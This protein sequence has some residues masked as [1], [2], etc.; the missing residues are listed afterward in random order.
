MQ[1]FLPPGG[2]WEG[3]AAIQDA[4]QVIVTNKSLMRSSPIC[5]MSIIF[6]S[7]AQHG[8]IIDKQVVQQQECLS[9]AHHAGSRRLL[10]A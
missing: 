4:A 5:K 7:Q 1:R 3:A 9:L 10:R 6:V 8:P 2:F